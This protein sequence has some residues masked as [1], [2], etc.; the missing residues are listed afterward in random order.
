MPKRT[1][2]FALENLEEQRNLYFQKSTLQFLL[3]MVEDRSLEVQLEKVVKVGQKFTYEYDFGSTTELNLLDIVFA[4]EDAH[5][6]RSNA[7][8]RL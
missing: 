3:D 7:P 8:M 5:P 6:Q 4:G 1:R 2:L